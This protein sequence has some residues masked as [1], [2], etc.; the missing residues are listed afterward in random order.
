MPDDAIDTAADTDLNQ[1]SSSE[2]STDNADA[3]SP[4]GDNQTSDPAASGTSSEAGSATADNH[5]EDGAQPSLTG[6][7]EAQAES[8]SVDYE[9]QYKT[10]QGWATKVHQTNL[11]LRKQMQELHERFTAMQQSQQKQAVDPALKPWDEG[12]ADHE[13]FL[14]LV[15]KA[16][17]YDELI[18]G[19]ENPE[20]VKALQQ[21]QLRVLGEQG[22]SML[23]DWRNDVRRQE[24]E[25]RLNPKAFYAKLIRQEAQPVVRETLQTTSQNYQQIAQARD[26][27][28]KWVRDNP[29]IATRDNIQGVLKLMES[30]MPFNVASMAVE[31]EHYRKMTST[32][33][34]AKASA[35][36]KERLLQGN[37]AG[38]VSRNPNAGKKIDVQQLRKDKG[39]RNGREFIDELFQLDKEGLL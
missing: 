3:G 4:I 36:E 28:Q 34:K 8:Q 30:G 37:A 22:I 24:R 20:I 27:A 39:I 15:D 17:Y 5:T 6:G 13:Q 1:G 23:R 10:V 19:E 26:E 12:H 35:E 33:A 7:A 21:K 14:R 16:E 2:P 31:R 11:E 29:E 32:A 25:R 18:Q 38:A 9:K